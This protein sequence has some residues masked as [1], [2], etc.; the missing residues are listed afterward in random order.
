[1]FPQPTLPKRMYIYAGLSLLALG[2][3]TGRGCRSEQQ[4]QPISTSVQPAPSLEQTVLQPSQQPQ[5]LPPQAQQKIL[6]PQEQL[7]LLFEQHKHRYPSAAPADKLL[8]VRNSRGL[9]SDCRKVIRRAVGFGREIY[10]EVSGEID[11][12]LQEAKEKLQDIYRGK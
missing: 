9:F 1:M 8:P 5:Q 6:T 11:Y 10:E 7:F 3:C 4:P 2:Y 12:C